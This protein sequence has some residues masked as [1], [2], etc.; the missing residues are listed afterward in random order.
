MYGRLK[1]F[2]GTKTKSY[3]H[4]IFPHE[5]NY[6]PDR[7]GS[8]KLIDYSLQQHGGML[9]DRGLRTVITEHVPPT[10][11]DKRARKAG[12]AHCLFLLYFLPAHTVS[13]CVATG[14]SFCACV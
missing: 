11:L 10:E 13:F 8:G 4:G 3:A 2:G 14:R 7:D 5:P 12:S 1:Q 9:C 6:P